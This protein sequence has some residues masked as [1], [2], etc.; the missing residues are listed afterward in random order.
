MENPRNRISELHF[1]N[2]TDS[3]DIQCWKVNFKTEV[4][5]NSAWPTVTMLWIKEVEIGKSVY[6]LTTSQPSEG[7]DFSDIEM[8]DAKIA[9]A[10]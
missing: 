8:L 9:S 4:C 6:D 2:F 5:S 10:L 3:V 1:C 7:R